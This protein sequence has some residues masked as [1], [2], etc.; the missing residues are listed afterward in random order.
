M[1]RFAI[2]KRLLFLL[3]IALTAPSHGICAPPS[4]A[5]R[6]V[7]AE[8]V[9]DRVILPGS[10]PVFRAGGYT[11]RIVPATEIKFGKGLQSLSDV[12]TNTWAM[13]EGKLDGSG[14]IVATKAAFARLKFPKNKPDPNAVQV[15]EF[16]PGSKIDTMNGFTTG[17]NVFPLE[18]HAGW[19]GWYDVPS[20]SVEQEHIRRVGMKLVPQY[21]RDLPASDP[22]KIPFRFYVVDEKQIR[23]AIFCANGLVLVPVEVVNR[24]QNEDQLAAVLADGIAGEL[25][26]QAVNGREFTL[27][28]AAEMAAIG[29]LGFAGLIPAAAGSVGGLVVLNDVNRAAEHERGRMALA[30][31]ADAGF[32]PRQAPEAWRLLAPG[33]LPKDR[34]KLKNPERSLYLQNI[35]DTQSKAKS[36]DHVPEADRAAVAAPRS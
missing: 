27:K 31:T 35:L 1:S 6:P 30:F 28:D 25:L 16:P 11:F 10:E 22:A 2:S 14:S 15:T 17:S 8:G 29:S 26:L 12:G 34:T 23:S 13:L 18:D 32:D 36:G 3:S 24:L 5:D 21:Q 7:K 20:N 33:R 4:N 9:I 19:C